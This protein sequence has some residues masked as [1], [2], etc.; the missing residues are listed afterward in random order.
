[1]RAP[2]WMPAPTGILMGIRPQA[3]ARSGTAMRQDIQRSVRTAC[4]G[5][6][7]SDPSRIQLPRERCGG[8]PGFHGV[9]R[10][11]RS[12]YFR[13]HQIQP[14][15]LRA[16]PSK[17]GDAEPR[18]YRDNRRHASRAASDSIPLEP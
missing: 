1:M 2:A 10:K 12:M 7:G 11:S 8:R 4:G 5:T 14:T 15:L 16:N 18:G 9:A 3:T 6:D 13:V 17:D